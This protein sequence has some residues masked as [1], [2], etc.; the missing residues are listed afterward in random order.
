MPC[1]VPLTTDLTALIYII[2]LNFGG[3]LMCNVLYKIIQMCVCKT[4]IY[5]QYIKHMYYIS[6]SKKIV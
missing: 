5:K 4:R 6:K 1:T 2:E 3:C